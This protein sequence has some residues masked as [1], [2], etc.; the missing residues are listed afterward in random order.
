MVET[1]ERTAGFAEIR[2]RR[3]WAYLL[4]TKGL[5]GGCT[6]G[7]MNGPERPAGSEPEKGAA[8]QP[9]KELFAP[10]GA[11][12][13]E[14]RSIVPWVI[15]GAVVLI[16]AGVILTLPHGSKPSSPGTANPGGAGLAVADPYAPHL[17]ISHLRMSQAG[18]MAGGQ[19]TYIDGQITNQGNRTVTGITAQL[20]FVG[21]S[22]QMVQKATLQLN[23]IRTREPYVDTEPVSANPIQ[24]GQTRDFRL[25]VDSV[26]QDWN[27][28]DPE[29]RIIQVASK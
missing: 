20:A 16:V 25:I 8:T 10:P 28:N 18:N 14:P 23:L 7:T 21:F 3:R 11:R 2:E 1:D 27:Q 5:R 4:F 19:T 17:A 13:R 12:E 29:I 24:P 26:T 6:I 15:A 22:G 9:E